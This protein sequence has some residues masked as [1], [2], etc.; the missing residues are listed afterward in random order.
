MRFKVGQR[1][2]VVNAGWDWL[3]AKINNR[4]ATIVAPAQMHMGAW[5]YRLDI[6]GL[7]TDDGLL[8]YCAPDFCLEPLTGPDENSWEHFE[9]LKD[10]QDFRIPAPPAQVVT[11]G[12]GA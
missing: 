12:D 8:A 11:L 7:G 1:V 9:S 4:P 5:V 3:G 10:L 2:R 6:D